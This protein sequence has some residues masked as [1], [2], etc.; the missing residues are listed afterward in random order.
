M[1]RQEYR[2]WWQGSC[3]G[4]SINFARVDGKPGSLVAE[5]K[6]QRQTVG[7]GMSV[8]SS[9]S[10]PHLEVSCTAW[11]VAQPLALPERPTLACCAFKHGTFAADQAWQCQPVAGGAEGHGGVAAGGVRAGQGAGTTL[12]CR[13]AVSFSV[14]DFRGFATVWAAPLQRPLA[15]WAPVADAKAEGTRRAVRMPP[16]E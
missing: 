12:Q 14:A 4:K 16:T 15:P 13:T 8:E 7:I 2:L 10:L 11:V 1:L 6:H 3:Q 9:C 5:C